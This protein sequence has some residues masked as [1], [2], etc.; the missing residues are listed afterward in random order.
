MSAAGDRPT[1]GGRRVQLGETASTNDVARELAAGGAAHGTV[2]T[3]HLQT[4]GRGR[5]GRAWTAPP[6]QALLCSIVVRDPPALLPLVGA[7]AAAETAEAV[8]APGVEGAVAI[9]WPNDVVLAVDDPAADGG[10][11]LRKV[12]GLLA[13][14]RPGEGW[15]VL[16]VGM[17]VALDLAVLPA[18]VAER[19]GSLGRGPDDVEEALALLLAALER[20]LPLPAEAV[21]ERWVARDVLLGRA[22][23]WTSSAPGA[24]PAG[25][26]TPGDPLRAAD[27][28]EPVAW[29]EGLAEGIEA[30]GRL[31]VRTRD[32]VERL[33]AADVHLARA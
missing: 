24:R 30:D 5:Q 26:V 13:E 4:S 25:A 19:A 1:L 31:R 14:G 33:D 21:R 16:G 6:R 28:D 8:R 17:N 12:C 7:L 23:R 9:K 29:R 20:T 11:R 2:V 18:D 27:E 22:V 3:A 10:R 32:G 15:A